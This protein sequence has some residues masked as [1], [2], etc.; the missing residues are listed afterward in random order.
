MSEEAP[1]VPQEDYLYDWSVGQE[2]DWEEQTSDVLD[3]PIH[4][5]LKSASYAPPCD[6][7]DINKVVDKQAIALA[8][9]RTGVGQEVEWDQRIVPSISVDRADQVVLEQDN[10]PRVAFLVSTYSSIGSQHKYARLSAVREFDK[11]WRALF[12]DLRVE[13]LPKKLAFG[14]SR[15]PRIIESR[16]KKLEQYLRS[17][18]Q[19]AELRPFLSKFLGVEPSSLFEIAQHYKSCPPDLC[20]PEIPSSKLKKSTEQVNLIAHGISVEKKRSSLKG[21]KD[22]SLLEPKQ[23]NLP[24]ILLKMQNSYSQSE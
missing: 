20:P 8:L 10:K 19:H 9:L 21:V 15:S 4:Q 5:I 14:L 17:V 12:K 6:S 11:E 23:M 22:K 2:L 1:A 18:C 16:R 13:K 7:Y 3:M 24:A